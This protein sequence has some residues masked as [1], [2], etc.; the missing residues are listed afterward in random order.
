MQPGWEAAF[1]SVR[2]IASALVKAACAPVAPDTA[3]KSAMESVQGAAAEAA[4]AA[5]AP[6][7]AGTI[8]H[9]QPPTRA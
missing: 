7:S 5:R 9:P 8:L 2:L 4:W 6:S 3:P 1:A